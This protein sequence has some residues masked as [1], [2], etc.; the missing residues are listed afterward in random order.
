MLQLTSSSTTTDLPRFLASIPKSEEVI[1]VSAGGGFSSTNDGTESSSPSSS[2]GH[3]KDDD[4]M[5]SNG[6]EHND[7]PQKRSKRESDCEVEGGT[8]PVPSIES[9]QST[10]AAIDLPMAFSTGT[11]LQAALSLVRNP[12]MWAALQ[13]P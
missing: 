6:H 7:P 12:A 5:S 1:N 2:N 8:S 9:Q 11:E 4:D 10:N 3:S 13:N